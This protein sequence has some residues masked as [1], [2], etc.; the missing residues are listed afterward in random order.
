MWIPSNNVLATDLVVPCH[1]GQHVA[2][3]DQ[4]QLW[5]RCIPKNTSVTT[6]VNDVCSIACGEDVMCCV[7]TG[8]KNGDVKLWSLSKGDSLVISQV[9]RGMSS[10]IQS[11]QCDAITGLV[12]AAS[13]SRLCIWDTSFCTSR[14]CGDE[15][16]ERGT[17][18]GARCEALWN[19]NR[20]S[21]RGYIQNMEVHISPFPIE[22][23]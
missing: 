21:V 3:F 22:T 20:N 4:T 9:L 8:H 1:D 15:K 5:Y 6:L 14:L 18:A 19:S 7:C 12:C 16:K 10:E 13:S 17:Y 2:G 23:D 11:I